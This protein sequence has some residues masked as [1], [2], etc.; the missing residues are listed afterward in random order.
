[1]SILDPQP[2]AVTGYPGTHKVIMSLGWVGAFNVWV[3]VVDV[4]GSHVVVLADQE[5]GPWRASHDDPRY[6][7]L[8]GA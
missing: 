1:M 3:R 4:N 7:G 6:S 2:I 8:Q 5:E